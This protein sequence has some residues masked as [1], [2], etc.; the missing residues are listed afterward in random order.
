M[1]QIQNATAGLVDK[2]LLTTVGSAV[3]R[4]DRKNKAIEAQDKANLYS[5]TEVK[6]AY[7]K[8]LDAEKAF[9]E[10]EGEK[11][12]VFEKYGVKPEVSKHDGSILNDA[13]D[14]SKLSKNPIS[15]QKQLNRIRGATR[16]FN[17]ANEANK[18]AQKELDFK[19]AQYE[20]FRERAELLSKRAKIN[21]PEVLSEQE[22]TNKEIAWY[23]EYTR[24]GKKNG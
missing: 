24:G 16:D 10:A 14:E 4:E 21:M 13:P 9:A 23:N 3:T 15:R 8:H 1:G 18:A 7:M 17:I 19:K 22:R 20:T 6:D 11:D 5:N 2:V 12:V